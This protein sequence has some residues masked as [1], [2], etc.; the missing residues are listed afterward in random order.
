MKQYG[1]TM[2][3]SLPIGNIKKSKKVPSMR[4]FDLIIQGISDEDTIGHLIVFD[5]NFDTKNASE[6]QLFFYEIYSP[7][8]EKKKV[9]LANERSVFQL[10]DAMRLNDKGT[11]SSFD[12]ITKTHGTIDEQ[13]VIPLYAE[14]LHFL[15]LGCGWR[16]NKIRGHYMFEQNKFKR[17]FV[18][19][20]Q[21]S[22]QKAQTDMEKDFYKFMNNANVGY[23]CRDNAD[24]CYFSPIYDDIDQLLYVKRY[25][26]VFD[27]SISDFV[28]SEFFER[29]IEE[30]FL[31]KTAKLDQ[32]DDYHKAMKNSLKMQKRKRC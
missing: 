28:S 9:L 27:Q 15:L 14:H 32:N 12:T 20:N 8:F 7:I 3:K 2:T 6:K 26:S 11:I 16:V 21:V 29:Q 22:K 1:N 25:Q 13:I 17:D 10:L 5:I 18:I 23:D 4:E 30:E 31:N 24:N 19:M